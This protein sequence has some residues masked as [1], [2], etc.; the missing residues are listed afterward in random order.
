MFYGLDFGLGKGD[1]DE[2]YSYYERKSNS[3]NFNFYNGS[4]SFG[5]RMH[6][7]DCFQ[8]VIGASVGVHSKFEEKYVGNSS[9]S[10]HDY[11]Y[12][13]ERKFILAQGPMVKFLFG[14]NRTWAE[15]SNEF[16]FG[17]SYAAY[18]IKAGFTYA[19]SKKI[20]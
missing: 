17:S 11:Y 18:Y 16:V 6:P 5:G 9:Y 19:P 2:N 3:E 10:N 13:Y 12:N 4:F 1:K 20:K 7:G 8:I 14:T 15:I